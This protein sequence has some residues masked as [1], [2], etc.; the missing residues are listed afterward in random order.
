[1]T[2]R[3]TTTQKNEGEGNRTAARAYNAAQESY[4]K[5]GRWK[6]AAKDAAAAL[7]GSEGKS[8]RDAEKK[9]K[10]PAEKSGRGR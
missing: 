5:S 1:M 8:L 9:A 10:R 6:G 2:T 3:K 7:D 4:A